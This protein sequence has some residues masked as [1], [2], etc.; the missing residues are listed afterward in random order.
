MSVESE[1]IL[2]RGP[3]GL[4]CRPHINSELE[5]IHVTQGFI[6]VWVGGVS[7][8]VPAGHAVLIFP[9]QPRINADSRFYPK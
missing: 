8:H 6:D 5:V 3:Y 9:H 2:L 1:S 7:L 4:E